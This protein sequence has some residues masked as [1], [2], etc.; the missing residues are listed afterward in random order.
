MWMMVIPL[1]FADLLTRLVA[2]F[3]RHVQVA[4][5]DRIVSEWFGE[6]SFGAFNSV[7]RG[8]DIDR[9]FG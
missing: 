4:Q 9:D 5:D 8:V 1:P 7:G 6:Y 3:V 2:V